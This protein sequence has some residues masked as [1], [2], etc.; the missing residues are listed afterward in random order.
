MT[1]EDFKSLVYAI[2]TVWVALA[3]ALVLLMH[4]GFSLLEAGLTRAKNV[5]N[6]VAKNMITVAIGGAAYWAIGGALAY[7]TDAG[8]F[9]GTSGFFDPASVLG[10]GTQAVFQLV[11]AATAATI[12][13]GA[14]AERIEFKA[15]IVIALSLTAVIYPIVSHW[16]WSGDGAWLND[17]GFYDFAGSTLVHMTGGTAALV[18]VAILGPRLGKYAKDGTPRAIPGHNIPFA[19]FGVLVLFVGWFGF[20]GGSTLAAFGQAET[21]GT[22]LMN[23]TIAGSFGAL[24]A[25][26]VNWFQAGKPDPAM[27]GNGALAGLVGITAGPDLAT[28]VWSMVVGIVCGGIVV[29]AVTA[30]DRVK[31]DDPVGATSVHLVCGAVG[32]LFVGIYAAGESNGAANGA[33]ISFANQLIGVAAV[34]SFVALATAIVTFAVRAT[35]GLRVPQQY[36]IEG[37][38][39]N[40]H[41]VSGYAGASRD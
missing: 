3:A 13:S 30:F 31:I 12:V 7:G 32:T 1:P 4:L 36:E 16:K 39:V 18:V 38:D 25:A 5:G 35:I 28:G 22:V 26:G 19:I 14:V 2:D 20:N 10:D 40:E 21:I 29:F 6:I 17:L 34:F 27:I 33:T 9:I 15:Y 8:G 11:F 37:L 24:A 41:G 23:T